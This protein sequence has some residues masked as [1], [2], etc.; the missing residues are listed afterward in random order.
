MGWIYMAN[1]RLPS[2]KFK[3]SSMLGKSNYTKDNQSGNIGKL[4]W[5]P[6]EKCLHIITLRESNCYEQTG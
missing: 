2:F 5:V 6:N 3:D 1:T 4:G